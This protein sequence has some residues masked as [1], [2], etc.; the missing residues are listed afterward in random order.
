M[1]RLLQLRPPWAPWAP[2]APPAPVEPA[3]CRAAVV[4]A[5]LQPAV[6]VALAVAVP[7]CLELVPPCLGDAPWA[8]V[9]ADVQVR[10]VV[11]AQVLAE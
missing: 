2:C 11:D 3:A 7:L 8:A 9:A 1:P 6:G 10:A 4:P 5:A